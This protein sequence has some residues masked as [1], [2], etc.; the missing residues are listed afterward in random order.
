MSLTRAQVPRCSSTQP[1]CRSP[2][3]R[4]G[5]RRPAWTG[6]RLPDLARLAG[7]TEPAERPG[8]V[9]GAA[10]LV[11]AASLSGAQVSDP[12]SLLAL[13]VNGADLSPDHGYPAR[14]IVPGRPGRA[15]H[16]VGH[17]DHLRRTGLTDQAAGARDQAAGLKGQ[18][19]RA[20]GQ[21]AGLKGQAAGAAAEATA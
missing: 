20:R 19:A 11:Q 18:A 15:Q 1:C 6:V 8:R 10:G 3:S 17:Q 9:A 5:P 2:A 4:A 12:D 14:V 21:A 7:V 16:Q 13:R